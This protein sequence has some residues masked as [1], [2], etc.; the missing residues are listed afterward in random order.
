MNKELLESYKNFIRNYFNKHGIELG[1]LMD[2]RKM[3]P[4]FNIIRQWRNFV[5]IKYKGEHFNVKNKKL[6]SGNYGHTVSHINKFK[7]KATNS[8]NSIRTKLENDRGF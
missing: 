7:P 6:C 8:L 4:S 1:L 3:E 2:S 5:E